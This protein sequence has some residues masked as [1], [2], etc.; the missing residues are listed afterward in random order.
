VLLKPGDKVTVSL[1]YAFR[2]VNPKNEVVAYD[3]LPADKPEL[4]ALFLGP[5]LLGV[6]ER[7]N[8]MFHGEPWDDNVLLF[9]EEAAL[10]AAA[11]ELEGE[12]VASSGPVLGVTYNHSGFVGEYAVPL[13]P[14]ASQ[15]AHDQATFSYRHLVKRAP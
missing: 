1:E 8:P 11:G 9:P 5:W 13:T 7:R 10:R 2:F 14:V 4:L 12:G 3:A 15:T 6:D